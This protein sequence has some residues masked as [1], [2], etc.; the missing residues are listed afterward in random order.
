MLV[1]IDTL[2]MYGAGA[3]ENSARDVGQMIQGIKKISGQTGAACLLLHHTGKQSP[4]NERGSS[5]LRGA[6]DSMFFL[7]PEHGDTATLRCAKMK[8]LERPQDMPLVIRK[9]GLDDGGSSCVIS[10]QNCMG[11]PLVSPSIFNEKQRRILEQLSTLP[12]A[13]GASYS[14]LHRS[15]EL[16]NSTFNRAL[17]VVV[18]RGFVIKEGEGRRCVYR[19]TE[20]GKSVI[21][22]ILPSYSHDTPGSVQLHSL[23]LPGSL[24]PGVNGRGGG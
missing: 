17:D 18:S 19:I 21:A 11:A 10:S 23:P 13:E 1:V 20:A 8:D 24:E 7:L 6:A 4:E 15:T 14:L 12:L 3:D 5:A 2:A 9:V 16:P 22:P